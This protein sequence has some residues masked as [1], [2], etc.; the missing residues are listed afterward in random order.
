MTNRIQGTIKKYRCYNADGRQN[1][2]ILA[3]L[4]KKLKKRD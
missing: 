4:G 3:I 1:M 2:F